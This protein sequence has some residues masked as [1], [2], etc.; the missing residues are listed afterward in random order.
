VPP[1]SEAAA[2]EVEAPSL[3]VPASVVAAEPG[4]LVLE[5]A[6]TAIAT[7]NTPKTRRGWADFVGNERT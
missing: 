1:P 3:C 2:S 4:A 6:K 7:G 5:H